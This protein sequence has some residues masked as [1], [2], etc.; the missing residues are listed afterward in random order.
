MSDKKKIYIAGPMRG[1]LFYNFPAFDDA[2][3][4][5]AWLGWEVINPAQ[6]DRDVGFDAMKLDADSDW[7]Q[8]PPD[9]DFAGCI[10]RDIEAVK[11]CDAIYLL[12]GWE[13]SVGANAEK[14]LAE[15]VG[16]KIVYANACDQSPAP[17]LGAVKEKAGVWSF[18]DGKEWIKIENDCADSYVSSILPADAKA[19][20]TYPLYSGLLKYF[21]DALAVVAH[22]SYLGNEQHHP[23]T[24]LHWDKSKSQDELDAL[25][26]H[27][28]EGLWGEVAWRAL[29]NLQRKIDAGWR[30]K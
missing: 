8:D 18:W 1:I 21:P 28:T 14:A 20:K 16:K 9:F 29:A 5:L 4:F 10:E 30:P 12:K 22:I 23:G 19:R 6:L 24:E 2:A 27:I 11:K 17:D 25:L 26:R 15:W 3:K 7:H 13:N